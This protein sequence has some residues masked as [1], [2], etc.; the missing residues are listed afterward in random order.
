[1]PFRPH[2][3]LASL[4]AAGMMPLASFAGKAPPA[5]VGAFPHDP[6]RYIGI[7][8]AD[9]RSHPGDYR[10]VAQAEALAQISR[11]ISVQVKAENTATQREDASGWEENYA[12][13]VNTL[14]R[15]ELTG[16]ELAG[17][18]ETSE[19]FWALYTLEKEGFRRSLDE[20]E[21]RFGEWL[22]RESEAL[23]RELA[24][25]RIQSAVDRFK[26]IGK[27]YETSYE[28]NPLLSGR[29]S[30]IPARYGAVSWK[31][32]ANAGSAELAAIPDVWTYSLAQG[33]KMKSGN[34][35]S[36][37]GESGRVEVV[38]LDGKNKEK[39]KGPLSLTI[40]NRSDAMARECRVETDAE[41]GLDLER[42][43]RECG[44]KAGLWRVEWTGTGGRK[45]YADV[46]AEWKRMDLG[47]VVRAEGVSGQDETIARFKEA[48]AGTRNPAFRVVQAAGSSPCLEVRILELSHDSLEGMHFQSLR[49]E[50]SIPGLA[51]ALVVRGKSGHADKVRARSRAIADFIKALEGIP[52]T[53][54]Q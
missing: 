31:V 45:V 11:E 2:R 23:E 8:R 43:F 26:R 5:W 46:R 6:D 15:N 4:L 40:R 21:A 14:S 35:I 42:P 22:E 47:I 30:A 38:L 18:H 39:W 29:T 50:V 33:R 1:M 48:L 9:K 27:E 52:R 16:H 10:E 54:S 24:G 12:Q 49:A 51:E 3:W 19:E 20:K 37:G 28:G 41:G 53:G 44:L 34:G 32:E 7:G 36:E 13:R 25:R 17:V